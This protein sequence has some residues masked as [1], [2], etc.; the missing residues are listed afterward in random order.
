M[1]VEILAITNPGKAG[2]KKG[3]KKGNKMAA[4]KGKKK[5]KKKNP[6]SL[7]RRAGTR[8]KERFFGMNIKAAFMGAPPRWA[9]MFAA[10]WMAKKFP[11]VEG[12][13]DRED[14]AWSNY[15]AGAFGGLLAGFLA[16]N[17]KRGAGQKVLEG[18]IDLMGYKL[19][20]NEIVYRSDFLTDQFG[21]DE[22]VVMLGQGQDAEPGD[23]LLGDDG[24]MYM[25]G[26]D[27]YTRPLDERH[28]QLATLLAQR[29]AEARPMGGQLER[30]GTLG[31][32]LERP[33]T[34]GEMA[35]YPPAPERYEDPFMVAYSGRG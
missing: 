27:G 17:I 24:E 22:P 30:P 28:R 4:K 25:M 15:L 19:I 11:G 31:G 20:E 2:K 13:G 5:T 33:G 32:E 16:E 6:S 34:L 10:K 26:A 1:A 35:V 12:G 14:W 29:A 23:L 8:A 9:G 21:Y 3:K 18:A 7:A